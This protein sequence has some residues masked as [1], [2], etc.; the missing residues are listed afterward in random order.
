MGWVPTLSDGINPFAQL[1][2]NF[3]V[4]AYTFISHSPDIDPDSI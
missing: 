2:P 1:P 3:K 4:Q